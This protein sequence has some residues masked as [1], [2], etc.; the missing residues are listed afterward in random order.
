MDEERRLGEARVA[1][2]NRRRAY[3]HDEG[4]AAYDAYCAKRTD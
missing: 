4:S 2:T 3:G 1:V